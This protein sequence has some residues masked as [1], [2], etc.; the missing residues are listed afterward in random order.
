MSAITAVPDR[1]DADPTRPD[2]SPTRALLADVATMAGRSIRLS[3]R[4]VDTLL[5][6]IVLPLM[7]MALFVY[8]FG[9]AIDGTGGYIDYVVPGIVL[10]CVGFGAAST[11]VPVAAD[12]RSGMVD[13][14]RSMDTHAGA[15]VSGH[16]I[17]SVARNLL[18]TTVVVLAA[19]AMG[20]RPSAT[21]LEWLALTALLVTYVLGLSFVS[22]GIGAVARSPESA[23]TAG[24]FM[25]FVP[26][27]SSA[28]VDTSTM[29]AVLRSVADHQPITPII[30]T[31]RGL[32][33]GGPV[34]GDG[35]RAVAW[36]VALVVVGAVAAT[37]L[38][39]RRTRG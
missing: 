39:R 30:E 21:P 20:F 1:H 29:P 38:Y 18:S 23:S 2:L 15:V 5:M 10:L 4:D 26:Y 8:V 31:A 9:G 25:L 17:A 11:A 19:V 28:F 34:G 16:V 12:L 33:T 3:L 22:A 7:L 37:T 24:F 35:W 13:R 14:L 27:L 36:S 6:A 32:L